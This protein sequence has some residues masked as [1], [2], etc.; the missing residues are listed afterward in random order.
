MIKRVQINGK[1]KKL[2]VKILDERFRRMK[3]T[4]VCEAAS[5]ERLEKEKAAC[6]LALN[7]NE[8]KGNTLVCFSTSSGNTKMLHGH[9]SSYIL[10]D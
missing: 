3:N 8:V 2:M 1:T 9:R 10:A 4:G 5:R 7:S 6:R